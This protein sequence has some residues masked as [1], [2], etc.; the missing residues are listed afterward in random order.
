MMCRVA[1]ALARSCLCST[2]KAFSNAVTEGMAAR[3]PV[4]ATA[5]AARRSWW[6]RACAASCVT[7]GRSSALAARLRQ[8]EASR[9][10]RAGWAC[11]RPAFVEATIAG[12]DTDAHEALYRRALG[13]GARGPLAAMDASA[14]A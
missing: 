3:L 1:R 11:G 13:L 7:A 2:R 10:S 9:S 6:R 8:L 4:V 12:P 5:W 14:A